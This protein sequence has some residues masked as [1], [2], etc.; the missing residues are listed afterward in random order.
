MGFPGRAAAAQRGAALEGVPALD[1]QQTTLPEAWRKLP[2]FLVQPGASL[3]LREIRRGDSDPAPDRLSLQRHLWLSFDGST[4]TQSDRLTG[5]ISRATRLS[6]GAPARLG[7]V[8]ID[9]QDQLITQ[10]AAGVAGI[11][12]KRGPLQLSADSEVR[13]AP[14]RFPASGWQHDVDKLGVTLELP[15][16][17]R[18]AGAG[19]AAGR[20][21]R[22]CGFLAPPPAALEVQPA[23]TGAGAADLAHARHPVFRRPGRSARIS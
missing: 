8:A 14:R 16:G 2:A 9:G 17:W 4:L 23:P 1:P 7:R 20:T 11:E 13:D 22:R 10:D 15:P 5:E 21:G 12:V 6:M 19:F 3:K 18:L